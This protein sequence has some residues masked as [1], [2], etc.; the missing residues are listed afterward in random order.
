MSKEQLLERIAELE[1]EVLYLKFE[2]N[3]CNNNTALIAWDTKT[4]VWEWDYTSGKVNFSAKKAQMLGYNPDELEPNVFSFT[5]KIHPDDYESTMESMREHLCGNLSVYEVE[6]RIRTKDGNWKWFYDKGEVIKRDLGGKP[7]KIVGIVND[8]THRKQIESENKKLRKAIECSKESIIITDA[9]GNIEYVNQYF[10][11]MTGYSTEDCYGKNLNMLRTKYHTNDYYDNLWQTIKSGSTW[12][13]EFLNL[14]KNGDQ[15]WESAIISPVFDE[16]GEIIN[17][18][19]VKRDITN[20]K[21]AGGK[22]KRRDRFKAI[23]KSM[24]YEILKP[25]NAIMKFSEL[26]L[27]NYNSF[28]NIKKY[29][30]LIS[31]RF[32]ELFVSN[33]DILAI[34]RIKCDEMAKVNSKFNILTLFTELKEF[35]NKP[36]FKERRLDLIFIGID[37]FWIYADY[38]KLI[39]IL[40]SLIENAYKFTIEGSIWVS[41][42]KLDDNILIFRVKDTG[43]GIPR[44]RFDL[45]FQRYFQIYPPPHGIFKGNGLSLSIVNGMVTLM[46]GKIWLESKIGVG[47]EFYFSIPLT[48]IPPILRC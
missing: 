27:S 30:H 19:G 16:K 1:E 12:E 11:K 48:S 38:N 34:S 7:L 41:V 13:G 45:I 26:L 29:S 43:V 15:Y 22:L 10:L 36:Q 32:K 23:V 4:A 24:S 31:Y 17:F 39:R 3:L 21:L 37:D 33:K 5:S 35:F 2:A 9:Y 18:V 47:S 42:N 44:D 40:Y 8:I 25:M 46:G 6:Y 20:L 28:D 14:K